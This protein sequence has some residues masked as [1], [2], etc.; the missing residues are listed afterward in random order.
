MRMAFTS[1]LNTLTEI[2][3]ERM[4]ELQGSSHAFDHVQRVYDTAMILAHKE[5]ADVELV[6]VGAVLHDIGRIIG[7]P[8]AEHGVTLAKDILEQ[9]DYPIEKRAKILKIIAEHPLSAQ[10][11][12]PEAQI[13]WDADKIDLIGIVGL[14]RAF[15]RAGQTQQPFAEAL[16]YCL[17]RQQFIYPQLKTTTAKKIAK[18]R[19]KRLISFLEAL[20]SELAGTDL[21]KIA[22]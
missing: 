15:H 7:D 13:I 6:Q 14:T 22:Y 9:L 11:E 12:T 5:S 4:A 17:K 3:K 18:G 16:N 2:V 8:H 19:Q 10:P 21:K 1:F 20:Q